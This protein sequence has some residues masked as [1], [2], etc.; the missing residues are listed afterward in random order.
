MIGDLN[1]EKTYTAC[2]KAGMTTGTYSGYK[3][4]KEAERIARNMCDGN[5]FPGQFGS[6]SVL[7]WNNQT[8]RGG[9]MK[10]RAKKGK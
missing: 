3:T 1:I 5:L 4:K 7:D 2:F 10:Y 9:N 8:V 6:W